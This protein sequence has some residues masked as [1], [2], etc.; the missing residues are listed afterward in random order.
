MPA[1]PRAG[2]ADA[3]GGRGARRALI[4]LCALLVGVFLVLP[5]GVVFWHAFSEGLRAY[6]QAVFDRATFRA[7][8]LTLLTTAIAVPLNTLFGLA[9]AWA[10]TKFDFRGK[11]LLVTLI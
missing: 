10:V 2:R 11:S 4:G 5:L 3:A 8:E 6:G 9:A 1:R 7:V